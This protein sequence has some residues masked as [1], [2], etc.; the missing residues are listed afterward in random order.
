MRTLTIGEILSHSCLTLITCEC[1]A[2]PSGN[3]AAQ[4][5]GEE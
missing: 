4:K 1:S 5:N 3:D 2:G